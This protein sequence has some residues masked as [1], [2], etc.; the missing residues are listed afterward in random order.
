ML[1]YQLSK[2]RDDDV[3]VAGDRRESPAPSRLLAGLNR[4]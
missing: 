3:G 4:G 2:V 1:S